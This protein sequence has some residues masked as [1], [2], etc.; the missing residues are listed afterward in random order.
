MNNQIN[1][2]DIARVRL[3]MALEY[4]PNYA[5]AHYHLWQLY[6]KIGNSEQANEH[7]DKF[8]KLWKGADPIVKQIYGLSSRDI[9]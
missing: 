4:N 6:R 8:N 2:L 9:D 7:Y 3:E 1:R 5:L